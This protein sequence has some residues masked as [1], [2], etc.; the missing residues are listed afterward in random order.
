VSSGQA[1]AESYRFRC[2]AQ[3]Q[4]QQALRA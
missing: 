2:G 1:L 3:S 4:K